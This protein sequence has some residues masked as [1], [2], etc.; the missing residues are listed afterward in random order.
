MS[1]FKFTL[2]PDK[3]FPSFCVKSQKELFQKWGMVQMSTQ[4]YSYD[5]YF[6]VEHKE[7]FVC[8]FLTDPMVQETLKRFPSSNK[9]VKSNIKVSNIESNV[10]SMSFFDRLYSSSL[11][12]ECG[13]IKKCFDE[14]VDDILVSDELRKMTISEESD[15]Y[16]LYSDKEKEEFIFCIFR[17]IILG[18]YCN[19]YEDEVQHY[20]ETTKHVY[21]DLV[22][23]VKDPLSTRLKVLSKVLKIDVYGDKGNMIFPG[24]RKHVQSFCYLIT[25]PEKRKLIVWQHLY[26]L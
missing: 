3:E 9:I 13:S 8:A 4:M 18:G 2:L 6:D 5:S 10:I 19:Q 22:T 17:H 1:S 24:K 26:D 21:K 20:V 25:D 16:N 14:V 7:D 11:V 15:Y 12:R 23:V